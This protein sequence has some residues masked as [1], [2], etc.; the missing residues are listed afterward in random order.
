MQEWSTLIGTIEGLNDTP[1]SSSQTKYMKRL[2]SLYL[3]LVFL[4]CIASGQVDTTT[5][6]VDSTKKIM[7]SAVKPMHDTT[8]V[9][10]TADTTVI[11]TPTNCYKEW[12]DTFRNRGARTVTDGTQEVVIAFKSGESCHCFMGKVDVA[13]G[14][15]KPPLYIQLEN[16]E[17]KTFS[18][19]GRKLDME[20][21]NDVGDQLWNITDGMSILFRTS[22]QENGRLF[23]Y[24]F[25][26]RH[27]QANKV[28][29]TPSEL[30][31]D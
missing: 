20:F 28:A 9:K 27:A 29:P 16:G 11:T 6:K 19:L 3:L 14:K 25:L 31:K 24:K 15:I 21:V 30:I 7:D 13:G 2:S 18:A 8:T 26:N 23:F 1:Y 4:P 12:Y 17:Y 22:S 10:K 5:K